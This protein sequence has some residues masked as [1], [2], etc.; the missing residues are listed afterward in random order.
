[1]ALTLPSSI[2]LGALKRRDWEAAQFAYFSGQ[3]DLPSMLQ[4]YVQGVG[5]FD[6]FTLHLIRGK[7]DKLA[8]EQGLIAEGGSV[9]D[10]AKR[11]KEEFAAANSIDLQHC[12]FEIVPPG[13]IQS[14]TLLPET[15]NALCDLVLP[16]AVNMLAKRPTR[17]AVKAY[18]TKGYELFVHPFCYQV[19]SREENWFCPSASNRALSRVALLKRVQNAQSI[20][21]SRDIVIV[22][23]RF[24]GAN[25]SHFLFDW[26]T[27]IGLICK[28]RIV[29]YKNCMFAMGGMP[30][31]FEQLVLGALASELGISE[32]QFFFPS[33]GTLFTGDFRVT[34]FSDQVESYL[35]PAQMAHPS[36]V[37]LLRRIAARLNTEKSGGRPEA[38]G[39]P[40]VYISRFDAGRRRVSNELELSASLRALGFESVVLGDLS[41][42]RQLALV[43]GAKHVVAPHGMGLTHISLHPGAPTLIELHNP[44]HGTD[45]YALLARAMGFSYQ[46]VVGCPTQNGF[47][48]FQIAVDA[49]VDAISK[50]FALS[51]PVKTLAV[52][53]IPSGSSAPI[54]SSRLQGATDLTSEATPP[55]SPSNFD[56]PVI[57]HVRGDP[58]IVTDSNVG[59]WIDIEVDANRL[60]TASCWVWIP[61]AFRGTAVELHIGEWP[62]Q[63]RRTADLHLRERWQQITATKTTPEGM[64]RCNVVLRVKCPKGDYVYSSGWRLESG[65]GFAQGLSDALR[66]HPRIA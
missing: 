50:N 42:E 57:R 17:P 21:T 26:V 8:T 22:Q 27:R 6:D 10:W 1:M 33:E 20:E 55:T 46:C 64:D 12:Y 32:S 61:Q 15:Q 34:W 56:S 59:A 19:F 2:A 29:D 9:L 35:H 18:W 52:N 11:L 44:F 14:E 5:V 65:F 51:E 54:E 23:D 38:V 41:V 66:N 4:H 30:G 39:F 45:A 25:F 48:D 37:S 7:L 49:V 62:K 16:P 58:G 24:P 28:S 43:S 31:R 53:K 13:L 60:Y 40:L 3:S 63:Y 47:D 36:S